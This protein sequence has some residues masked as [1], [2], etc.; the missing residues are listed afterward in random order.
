MTKRIFWGI[1]LAVFIAVMLAS[2]FITLTLY[3][4]YEKQLT[5]A[6]RAEAGYIGHSLSR[7]SDE[8]AYFAGFSSENRVTLVAPDGTVLYDSTMQAESM[9]NHAGRPEI[10]AALAAGRGENKRYSKTFSEMTIYYAVRT[11][12]GNVLRVSNTRASVLGLLMRMITM[13]ELVFIGVVVLSLITARVIAKRI[14]APVNELDLDHPLVNTV[15]DEL[16]P[17]LVRMEHQNYEIAQQMAALAGK[18]SELAAITE[19]MREGMILLDANGTVLSMNGS[20]AA[21]FGTGAKERVGLDMLCV[22]RDAAINDAVAAAQSGESNGVMF[23]RNS[24]TYQASASPVTEAG[25]TVGVV[26]LLTDITEQYSAE[27]SRREFTANVSHELKTPLTSISGYAEIMRDGLAK[28]EDMQ[29]FAA[30]I[31]GEANRLMALINDILALSQLDERRGLGEKEPVELLALANRVAKRLAQAADEKGIR[32]TVTGEHAQVSGFPSLLDE[33]TFNLVDNAVKYTDAGGE[34]RVQVTREAGRVVLAVED[35]GVGIP[36][37]AQAHVFERFYRVDKSHSKATGGTGLGLS[38]VK[39]GAAAHD[40]Q[41]K[42]TSEP[43]Q[44]T[45]VELVFSGE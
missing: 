10:A 14:V 37:E 41:V 11:A 2:I 8:R 19:N 44:G 16:S 26:L 7:E 6:L 35:T 18:R 22:T 13:F 4:T 3:D 36:K 45:C 27:I 30:R 32:L 33:M 43:G 31:H 29:A 5:A 23:T 21:I 17:L 15:Y 20:A 9:E 28:P 38:I 40:A 42:L 25:K 39:H 1:V 24:R 12:A 34:V